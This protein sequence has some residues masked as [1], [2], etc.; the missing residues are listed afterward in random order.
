[1]IKNPESNSHCCSLISYRFHICRL[2]T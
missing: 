1:M 2:R